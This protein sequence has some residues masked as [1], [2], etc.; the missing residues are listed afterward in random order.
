MLELDFQPDIVGREENLEELQAYLD[1]ASTGQGSTVILAGE[2]GIGKTRLVEEL[3]G[4][5]HAKG[6]QVLTGSGL[7]ESLTPY[8]P[9]MEALRSGGLEHLFSEEAPRVEGVY[10][11]TNTGLLIREMLREETELDP[12]MFASM[13]TTVSNFVRDTLAQLKGEEMEDTL[14]KLGYGDFTILIESGTSTNLAVILTGEENEFLIDD[15]KATLHEV[16]RRFGYALQDWDGKEEGLERVVEVLD[17]IISSGKFDGVYFGRGDPQSRRNLLFENVSLGLSRQAQNTP[18]LLCLEDLQWAD[19]SSLALMHYVSR[20][21]KKCGLLILGTYRPE[22]VAVEGSVYHPL[23]ETMQLMS[24][25]GLYKKVDLGRLTEDCM[26]D[27]LTALLQDIDFGEEFIGKIYEETEGNPLYMIELVKLLVD[28]GTLVQTEGSWK[29]TRDM[30]E[31]NV[32]SKICDV[33]V[34]RLNRVDEEGR[35]VLDYA[36]VNGDVFTSE[37][38]SRALDMNKVQ[39]LERLRVLEK[40]HK[41]IHSAEG[42]FKFDHAKVREVLYSEIPSELRMEYHS[43]IADSIETVNK[44]NLDRVIGDLAFHYYHCRKKDNARFYLAKAAEK[45]KDEFSN[46]EAIRFYGEA[47]EFEED[48]QSRRELL[49]SLGDVQELIGDYD[50]SLD[51]YRKALELADKPEGKAHDL[52]QIGDVLEKKGDLDESLAA[53]VEALNL[54]KGQDSKYEAHALN[55]IGLVHWGKGELD[56]AVEWYEKCRELSE[57]IGYDQLVAASLNNIGNTLL[58]RGEFEGALSNYE[59][60]LALREKA[61]DRRSVAHCLGNIGSLHY[62]KG[63]YEHALEQYKASLEI[64]DKI[65]DQQGIAYLLNNIGVLHEDKAEYDEALERYEESLEIL[66]KIGDQQVIAASLH[67]IGLVHRYLGDIDKALEQYR[68]S[69][70]L[71]KRIGF[72]AIAAYNHCAIAEVNL[73]KGDSKRAHEAIARAYDMSKE[74]GLQDC[75]AASLRVYGMIHRYEE[76]WDKA[77][78]R[79]E[80]SIKVLESIGM[81]KELGQSHYEFGIM[82]KEMGDAERAKTHLRKAVGLFEASK[83]DK[84]LDNAK[85]ALDDLL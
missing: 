58:Q 80:E 50:G 68:R 37:V 59:R 44:D 34:R 24:R 77:I 18:T 14:N 3:K 21:S 76:D 28:E 63:D 45:A 85:Q 5:A 74:M 4:E 53:F 19:P 9:F 7:Y 41:L 60:S 33:I 27:F 11:V 78:P 49:E 31:L 29:L 13:L 47:L 56:K 17:P 79:F 83:L 46:E 55:G 25:E 71:G 23:V 67:N 20:N 84:E 1:Q 39:L 81:N 70:E 38:L 8:M 62:H 12:D 36:S 35:K 54:I 30:E 43:I 51:T 26:V 6:F 22:D 2:A 64:Q 32:P 10:L 16:D 65:G 40:I 48:P 75:I 42:A 15:M 69:L 61:E 57:R 72:Q 52:T 73:E 66:E 82:Y